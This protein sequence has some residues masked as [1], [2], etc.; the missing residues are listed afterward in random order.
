MA[1]FYGTIQ[2]ARGEASRL[3]SA[4]S[5]LRAYAASWQGAVSVTLTVQDGVDWALVELTKHHGSGSRRIIYDGPVSG[6]ATL[7]RVA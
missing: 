4:G 5:G 1:H 3:G 6:N 7:K 2:G